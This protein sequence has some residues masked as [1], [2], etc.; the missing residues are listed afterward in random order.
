MSRVCGTY[1]GDERSCGVLVRK[2]EGKRT[3][4][5]LRLRWKDNNKV[6]L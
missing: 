3:L 5:K 4:R 2:A 6:D 1:G